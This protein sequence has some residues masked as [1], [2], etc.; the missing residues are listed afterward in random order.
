MSGPQLAPQPKSPAQVTAIVLGLLLVLVGLIGLAVNSSF[1]T[2]DA[3]TS[4]KFLIF[5][6][7]GWDDVVPGVAFG[8]VLLAGAPS[9]SGAR[10]AC[11]LVALG[12]LV[13]LVAG[14]V[15]GDSAFGF[16][17][18]GAADDALRAVLAVVLLLAARRSKDRRDTLARDRVVVGASEDDARIVG[19]GS[20]HVGGPRAI[21]PRIDRR[22]PQK[23]HP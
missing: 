7:N 17:P 14:L 4:D 18:A 19:P 15:D 6:V 13:L 5:P 23:T 12:Y 3:L 16:V 22:L 1:H 10:A 11:R 2:G 21:G 8:L 20:G 9:R